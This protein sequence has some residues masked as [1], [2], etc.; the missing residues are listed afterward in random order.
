MYLLWLVFCTVQV[1]IS[2]SLQ[3]AAADGRFHVQLGVQTAAE[4]AGDT[5]LAQ[6]ALC[7]REDHALMV[8]YVY[9]L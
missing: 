6:W 7:L 3:S 9:N 5:L 1:Y 4:W 8:L 2:L